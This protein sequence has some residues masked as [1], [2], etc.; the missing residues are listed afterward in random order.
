MIAKVMTC[1]V[2]GLEAEPV[3]VEVSATHGTMPAVVMVGL[4]DKAV[5][6]AKERVMSALKHLDVRLPA[7]RITINLA[8]ADLRKEGPSYDLPIAV[9][10]LGALGAIGDVSDKWLF[11]GE[12]SL[13]GELRHTNGILPMVIMAREQGFD[14]VYLPEVDAPEASLIEGISVMGVQ[15]LEQVVEHLT[16][17]NTLHPF[18]EPPEMT[19]SGWMDEY[20]HDMAFVKG[21][22]QAKRALEIAA[23]GGHNV[24]MSGPP[25][26][27]KTMLARTVPSI[28]PPLSVNEALEVTKI[29]SVTG[30]LSKDQPLLRVRPFRSP[31]HTISGNALVGGGRWP[32]PGEISLSHRGVLFLDEFPE[33]PSASLEAMRQPLEDGIVTISRVQGTLTFPAEFILLASMNP[34]PCGYAMDPDH[35]CTCTPQQITRYQARISGPMLDRIDLH[36][37]VPRVKYEKLA[38]A[39]EGE[40]SQSIRERVSRTRELQAQRFQSLG[41]TSLTN[42]DM[43]SKEIQQVC[44]LDEAGEK[45]MKLA[46]EQMHLSGRAYHRILR[47]AR[48]VADL[49]GEPNISSQHVAEALQYRPRMGS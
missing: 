45:M 28:L 16:M 49:E 31:H 12:L 34:C 30:L 18:E 21:Q 4:P 43:G 14:R 2:V 5:Q 1:A 9:G 25:G 13:D 22:E 19:Q 33:F 8:P 39:K 23:A 44:R 3:T 17:G 27:G 37:E 47:L 7:K 48:T 32:K 38:H 11:L 24:L 20:A 40:S 42:A 35:D 10:I 29:Y 41:S 15:K 36:V 26:S 6:E 46:V